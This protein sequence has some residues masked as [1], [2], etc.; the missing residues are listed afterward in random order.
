MTLEGWPD[1]ARSVMQT[2]PIAWVFFIT[3]IVLSSWVILNLVIGVVVDSMQSYT[4]EEELELEIEIL[5]NQKRM[6][7]EIAALR[8][9][10][11]K[12]RG[13]AGE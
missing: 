10:L 7:E 12:L 1:L 6:M 13:E 8:R 3:F 11:M 4:H 9:E 5:Q 2:H